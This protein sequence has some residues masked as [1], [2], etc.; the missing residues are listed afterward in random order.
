MFKYLKY[1]NYVIRYKWYVMLE[2]FKMGLIWRGL[3][4]DMS[5]LSLQEFIPYANF[6]HGKKKEKNIRDK[7]GYYKPTDTGDPAFDFAW[8]LHQKKNDHHWQWWILPEDNGGEKILE[9]SPCALKEM[10]CDWCGASKAQGHGG[11]SGVIIWYAVN[12]EKMRFHPATRVSIE[13]FL[14]NKQGIE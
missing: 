7:I 10:L 12:K 11:W 9:M 2:C 1:L 3:K 14:R 4:H 6:F 5:K 8:L 13:H